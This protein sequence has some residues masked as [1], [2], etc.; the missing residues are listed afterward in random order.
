MSPPTDYTGFVGADRTTAIDR[1]FYR[2][3]RACAR[4]YSIYSNRKTRRRV[5][6]K[7]TRVRMFLSHLTPRDK[8]PAGFRRKTGTID[9]LKL[10]KPSLSY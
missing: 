2:N 7:Y 6:A 8:R 5:G 9:R 4:S 3:A 1:D 10:Y